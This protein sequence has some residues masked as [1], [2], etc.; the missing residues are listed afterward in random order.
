LGSRELDT[1]Y[2]KQELKTL[3][4]KRELNTHFRKRELETLY[5]KRGEKR[6]KEK[7]KKKKRKKKKEYRYGSYSY[8]MRET[9]LLPPMSDNQQARLKQRHVAELSCFPRG[10]LGGVGRLWRRLENFWRRKWESHGSVR[11]HVRIHICGT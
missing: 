1:L 6:I 8:Q 4:R 10:L 7:R 3:C 11:Q 5:K 9:K 2:R